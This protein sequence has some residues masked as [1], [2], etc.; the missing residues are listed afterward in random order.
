MALDQSMEFQLER[1]LELGMSDLDNIEAFKDM[2]SSE[3]WKKLEVLLQ[4]DIDNKTRLIAQLA[5]D[6][7]K[8]RNQ[9]IINSSVRASI[10]RILNLV[11]N[12]IG[13]EPHVMAELQG[14]RESHLDE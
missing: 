7:D 9:L 10:Q 5:I 14:Y 6:P 12:T 1:A 8:N 11:D 3:G 4:L 13:M 2:K